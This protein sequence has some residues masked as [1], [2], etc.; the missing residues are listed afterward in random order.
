VTEVGA[1]VADG[2]IRVPDVAVLTD[3]DRLDWHEMT[4]PA[5]AYHTLVEVVSGESETRD[6]VTKA[7]EYAQAGLATYWVVGEHPFRPA[8]GIVARYANEGGTFSLKDTVLLSD[9]LAA[10][11]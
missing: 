4:L 6:K 3:G 7:E 8:D 9:L 2:T 11:R 10:S 5:S 1:K